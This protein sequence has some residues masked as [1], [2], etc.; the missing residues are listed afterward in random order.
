MGPLLRA[1]HPTLARDADRCGA[2]AATWSRDTAPDW[3]VPLADDRE[4]IRDVAVWR[5]VNAVRDTD[6]RPTG[7]PREDLRGYLARHHLD[8]RVDHWQI[9]EP[10]RRNFSARALADSIDP[11]LT[12]EPH[13]TALARQLDIAHR[14]GADIAALTRRAASQRPLPDEQ[15]AAAL[16]CESLPPSQRARTAEKSRTARRRRHQVSV[17]LGAATWRRQ[18]VR[19]L[20]DPI[21]TSHARSVIS[22]PLAEE[23]VDSR[24]P[25]A[26]ECRWAMSAT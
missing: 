14:D 26:G 16:R 9:V 6:A 5:A 18:R 24:T 15:P 20:A 1:P 21:S 2:D 12:H 4:L 11:R 17:S 25:C 22:Q 19:D 13:W 7:P 23:S 8:R 10:G 3:G